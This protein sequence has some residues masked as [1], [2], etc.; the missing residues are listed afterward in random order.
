MAN[1]FFEK[2]SKI[3]LLDSPASFYFVARWRKFTTKIITLNYESKQ[4]IA[5]KKKKKLWYGIGHLSK[6]KIGKVH[7]V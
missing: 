6:S 7:V 5:K 1:L 4:N 2:F 3:P